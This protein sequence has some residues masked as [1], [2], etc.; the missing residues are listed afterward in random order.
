MMLYHFNYGFPLLSPNSRV[1]APIIAT[2]PRDEEARK[3]NGVAECLMVP[4]P[5]PGYQEKVFFHDFAAD[6]NGQTFVALLNE[7][8]G[9]G[10]P[11]G[12]VER[13]NIRQLPQFTQWKMSC[14]GFYV[15]GIEPGT[16]TPIGRGKLRQKNELP[17]LEAQ[18][19]YTV[20]V[21]VEVLDSLAD[22]ERISQEAERLKG[23]VQTAFRKYVYMALRSSVRAELVE[24]LTFSFD[25]LR[26]N[27]L[28]IFTKYC[29][30]IY[31]GHLKG[32]FAL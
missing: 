1:V 25:K 23:I 6:E 13:F 32:I 3:D 17:F 12:I 28:Y 9:D 20:N 8:I 7:D 30:R 11:L 2:E 10:T 29:N 18:T 22:F 4:A 31:S 21:E 27:G 15:M 24:A 19:Q 5:V 26:T 14:Q 16:V